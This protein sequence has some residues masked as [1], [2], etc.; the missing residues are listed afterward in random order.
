MQTARIRDEMIVCNLVAEL[1]REQV[2]L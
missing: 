2:S 1:I